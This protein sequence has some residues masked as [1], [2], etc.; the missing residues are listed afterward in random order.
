MSQIITLTTDFGTKDGYVGAMKGKILS[1]CPN[2]QI[3]D[4]SHEIRPHNIL[5]ASLALMR[6]VPCF[7]HN[8]IHVAVIDPGVGSKRS[9]VLINS[10]G[11][12]LIGPDNGV[13]S[14]IVKKS[15]HK[16][17]FEIKEKTE[18]WQ[19]STSFDGLALFAP[20]A[21]HLADGMP[22]SKIGQSM[23]REMAIIPTLKPKME[24]QSLI[25][26]VRVF[27]RFGNGITNISKSHLNQMLH[28]SSIIMCGTKEF[29]LVSHYGEGNRKQPI[30]IINSDDYL[31][32]SVYCGNA[33]QEFGL[34]LGNDVMIR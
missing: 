15:T 18:F 24:G 16:E 14:D 26:K 31:E 6:S 7:P 34:K 8:S 9:P 5:E 28:H 10:E 4:I 19:T 22:I 32:L 23:D 3:I 2:A 27:D 30:A 17:I 1:I 12:W 29:K 21:A 11:R 25:G 20:V 33:Q 13:F